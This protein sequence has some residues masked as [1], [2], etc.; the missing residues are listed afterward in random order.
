LEPNLNS[1]R[2]ISFSLL[3]I[4]VSAT[5]LRA[6]NNGT[7]SAV[8]VESF[9]RAFY[10]Y[11]PSLPLNAKLQEQKET[12]VNLA[13][14]RT[15]YK[16]TYESIHD[17]KVTAILAIPKKAAGP[18]PAIVLLAGSGGHKDSDY[19]RIAANMMAG[20][21]FA[22]VSIDAQ[23]HGERARTDRT[24]DFHFIDKNTNRD[25]WIQT[26]VDLRRAV[27][28]LVSRPDI[29]AKRIGYLG[30]SQGGMVGGTF[31]GVEPRIKAA[32]LAVP[33]GGMVEWAKKTNLWKPESGA[34]LAQNASIVDPIHFIGSFSPRPLLIL[35]ATRDELIPRFATEALANAAREPKQVIWYQSGHTLAQAIFI[36][37]QDIQKFFRTHLMAEASTKP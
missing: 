34:D 3:I 14:T 30:F 33:G 20:L 25:A 16:L 15:R 10:D 28:Y 9:R 26:V 37:V 31:L 6:Q 8:T 4:L 2:S 23:Y 19:I 21:G 7:E 18:H 5:A 35:A 12:D 13:E 11:D 17:Q 1:L 22:S 24:G 36:A 29:D 32:I 27:D